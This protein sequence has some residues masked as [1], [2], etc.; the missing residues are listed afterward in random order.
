ML[1]KRGWAFNLIKPPHHRIGY[2]IAFAFDDRRSAKS[3]WDTPTVC[4]DC[5]SPCD[6]SY[7]DHVVHESHEISKDNAIF[8]ALIF[9]KLDSTLAIV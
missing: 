6:P 8:D 9:C 2:G 5:M 4:L 3:I 7:A 1:I